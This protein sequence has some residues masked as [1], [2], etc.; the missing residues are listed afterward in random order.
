MLAVI[1][2][3]IINSRKGEIVN[4]INQLRDTLNKLG[5][6]TSF[7]LAILTGLLYVYTINLL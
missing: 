1:T 3:D 7:G 2:G 4:W 6:L 5:T